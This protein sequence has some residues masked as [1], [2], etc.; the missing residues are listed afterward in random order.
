MS[1]FI[2]FGIFVSLLDKKVHKACS[3][4]EKFEVST[5]TIYRVIDRLVSAGLPVGSLPGKNG[6]VF[7]L[8]DFDCNT[9]F[10]TEEELA[11]LLNIVNSNLNICPTTASIISEKIKSFISQKQLLGASKLSDKLFIDNSG[12]FCTRL[13]SYSAAATLLEGCKSYKKLQFEYMGKQKNVEPYC[14]V[15][16]QGDYYLYGY[17]S[18]SQ[19]FRLYKASRMTNITITGE[20]FTPIKINLTAKPW[21]KSCFDMVNV[22][23]EAE[24]VTA[25]DI[26]CWAKVICKNS[27]AITI[28]AVNNLG[29]THKLMEYGDKIKIISPA[30]IAEEIKQE[31]LKIAN[32]YL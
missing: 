11:Y 21:N 29:L 2:E 28:K 10:F 7:L 19:S 9:W 1:N 15:Y 4:A 25:Q 24:P 30:S 22:V 12:W 14:V 5:K 23:L 3:L 13:Q 31:C 8:D 6:G 26:S 16:K 32:L 20:Q 27:K 17:C 18:F